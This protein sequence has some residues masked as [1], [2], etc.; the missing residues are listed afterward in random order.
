MIRPKRI[1]DAIEPEESEEVK[2]LLQYPEDTAGGIM[3]SELVSVKKHATVNDAFQAV[4]DAKDE[5]ENIHNIFVVDEEEKLIGTVPLQNLITMKRFSPI[6]EIIDEDIPSVNV[7]MD[8]GSGI[9]FSK[10]TTLFPSALWTRNNTCW[11]ESP[12]T[13]SGHRAGGNIRRYVSHRR[14][15]ARRHHFQQDH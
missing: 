9:V 14:P 13:I 1:L 10:N 8:R 11:E 6:L 2:E 3:Q 15:G 5:M 4:V 12:S 7:E